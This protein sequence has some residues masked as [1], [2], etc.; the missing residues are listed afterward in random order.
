MSARLTPYSPTRPVPDQHRETTS[1]HGG[2]HEP[3]PR[4]ARTLRPRRPRLDSTRLAN[5]L[6]CSRSTISRLETGA[7]TLDDVATI[8]RL[9][10]VLEITPT[11]LGITA[12]VTIHPPA[13]D[14]V[15]R[16]QL[17]TGLA[18]TAAAASAPA[19][20]AVAAA[21]AVLAETYTLVTRND[22][23]GR[24]TRLDHCRP[25]PQPRRRIRQPPGGRRSPRH[26][27]DGGFWHFL[28]PSAAPGT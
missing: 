2:R 23:A 5:R 8:R 21:A 7:Q 1:H 18:V 13:E 10:E 19:C 14:D 15:R 25:A 26:G 16:C 3:E 17:L 12:T 27:G 11:A 24:S 28:S 4:H 6:H 9:A 22:Q 20:A